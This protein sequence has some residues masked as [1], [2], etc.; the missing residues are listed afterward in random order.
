M[1][2]PT[3]KKSKGSKFLHVTLVIIIIAG[4]ICTAA[5]FTQAVTTSDNVVSR[6]V[7]HGETLGF[8]RIG[9]VSLG[10]TGIA[11]LMF[12]FSAS[13]RSRNLRKFNFEALE[14]TLDANTELATL[15]K[16]CIVDLKQLKKEKAKPK[17]T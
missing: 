15:I 5:S 3:L 10:V 7:N 4:F 1:K 12:V 9:F 13:A 16:G 2:E 8:V 11:L 17:K 14:T 6:V